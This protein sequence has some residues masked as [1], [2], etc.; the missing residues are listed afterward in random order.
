MEKKDQ[1]ETNILKEV[2]FK[3]TINPHSP[4]AKLRGY[5]NQFE[6]AVEVLETQKEQFRGFPSKAKLK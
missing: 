4:Y 3:I 5:L 1:S 6:F 2:T